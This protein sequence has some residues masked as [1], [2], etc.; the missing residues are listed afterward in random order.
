M[1]GGDDMQFSP[2]NIPRR[3]ILAVATCCILAAAGCDALDGNSIG[4]GGRNFDTT[5]DCEGR[6]VLRVTCEYIGKAP[7]DPASY[8]STHDYNKND[9]DFYKVTMENLTDDEIVVEGV[10]FRMEKGK[11][12]GKTGAGSDWI[13]TMWGTN[14]IGPKKTI[15]CSNQ[16]AWS[17]GRRNTFIKTYRFRVRGEGNE[18]REFA[19]EVPLAY[20]R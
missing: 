4:L 17:K 13:E 5:F 8:P 7:G 18:E 14:V 1:T 2:T 16:M 6:P 20:R 10:T 15:S 11:L 9:T 19:A 3:P 12:H